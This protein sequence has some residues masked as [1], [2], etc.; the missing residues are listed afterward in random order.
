MDAI[1]VNP[2][3]ADWPELIERPQ[4]N[5]VDLQHVVLDIINNVKQF[6]DKAVKD[7]STKFHGFTPENL[8]VTQEE[9]SSAQKQIDK[10]LKKAI[11]LAKKNIE[12]FHE[13][14]IGKI[15]KIETSQGVVCWRK[16]VPVENVGLYIPGGSAPLFS[17]LLMLAIP[18]KI[19]GCK[20]IIVTTPANKSGNVD[21]AILFVA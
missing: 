5:S 14:Q 3:K 17:T 9:I 15:K 18:A 2:P 6:G 13:A 1:I 21:A 10:S 4:I 11:L 7:Y 20:N 16:S 19:A 12:K 8:W